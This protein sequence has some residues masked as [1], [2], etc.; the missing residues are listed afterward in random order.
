MTIDIHCIVLILEDYIA[1]CTY[2]TIYFV[3]SDLPVLTGFW[4]ANLMFVDALLMCLFWG[5]AKE[6]VEGAQNSW[7]NYLLQKGLSKRRLLTGGMQVWSKTGKN[8]L[9]AGLQ[10]KS[11]CLLLLQSVGVNQK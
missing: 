10:T 11:D 3:L 9:K 6:E 5:N 8:K 2:G 7:K 4:A 1:T